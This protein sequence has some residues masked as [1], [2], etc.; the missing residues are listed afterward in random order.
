MKHTVEHLRFPEPAVEPVTE[1]CQIAGQ[2]LGADAMMDATNIAFDVGDQSMHPRQDFRVIGA[3]SC[4]SLINF[5]DH[6][7]REPRVTAY[8]K[9]TFIP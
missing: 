6:P 1:F 8:T 2:V 9:P 4:N 7:G 5:S 3:S